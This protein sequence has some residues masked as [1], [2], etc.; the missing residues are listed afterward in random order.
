MAENNSAKYILI[1]IFVRNVKGRRPNLTDCNEM[2]DGRAGHWLERQ[3]GIH[4]NSNNGPDML[5][6]ELKNQTKSKTT[7]GDWSA[8]YYI[9]N[10]PHYSN[11]FTGRKKIDKRNSFLR[12]FGNPNPD[13]NGRHSWSGSA[14]PKINHYNHF[15]QILQVTDNDD[16]AAIYSYTQDQRP[17]KSQI[18]PPALQAD[19]LVLAKWYG[20][21]LP[22]GIRESTRNKC[23]K[24]KLEDKFNDKGWFTC[25]MDASG[26]YNE[27]CFGAPMNYTN[28]IRLVQDG[29]VFFDS[30]MYE[31]N[32][33]PYSQWRANNDLWDNLIVER[34][35]SLPPDVVVPT[36]VHKGV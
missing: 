27:I 23:L 14:C 7:F 28:W 31:G 24:K 32:D 25:K 19:N 21:D 34:Y 22:Q 18:V 29:V 16:I 26:V 12:V 17:D 30:G 10:D 33:R 5:G 9:Y 13:K 35:N 11:V 8:N 2:H 36:A 1:E 15:G 6:Y 3:F 20:R 4:A